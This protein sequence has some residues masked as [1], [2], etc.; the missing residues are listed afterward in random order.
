MAL[1]NFAAAR[2]K[3]FEHYVDI[4]VLVIVPS[5][6]SANALCKEFNFAV[7]SQLHFGFQPNI[8]QQ[9]SNSISAEKPQVYHFWPSFCQHFVSVLYPHN[10]PEEKLSE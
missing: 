9:L 5:C 3:Q 10:T 6:M 8:V 1:K 2:C 7:S 4:D